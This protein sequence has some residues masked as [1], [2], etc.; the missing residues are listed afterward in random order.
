MEQQYP[1]TAEE[2]LIIERGIRLARFVPDSECERC[3]CAPMNH[4]IY[5]YPIKVCLMDLWRLKLWSPRWQD[6]CRDDAPY[7]PH[8][9]R[10]RSEVSAEACDDCR[11]YGMDHD[12]HGYAGGDCP[13]TAVC[14]T[15]LWRER[16]WLTPP[17]WSFGPGHP[18]FCKMR[19]Q[20]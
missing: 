12:I 18:G 10:L 11:Y 8:R 13:H 1:V 20:V 7:V 6:Y 3:Q 9:V 17:Q 14:L 15:D 5:A 16:P 4:T 2:L 19:E